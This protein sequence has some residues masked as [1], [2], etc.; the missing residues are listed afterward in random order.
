MQWVSN[1]M[2]FKKEKI[3]S[4]L[5]VSNFAGRRKNLETVQIKISAIKTGS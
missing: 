1:L 4:T 3:Q 5:V 2:T